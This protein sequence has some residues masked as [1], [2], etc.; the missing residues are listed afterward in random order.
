MRRLVLV[1]GVALLALWG[2]KIETR[3][4]GDNRIFKLGTALDHLSVIELGEPVLE[5]AAG[6]P[7]FKIEWR[8]NKVFVQP[9]DPEASTNLFIWTQ[10]GRLSYELMPAGTV[11][12]MH[13]AIDEEPV[14]ELAPP[15]S[16][17]VPAA[18]VEQPRIPPEMLLSST[19]V[20]MAGNGRRRASVEVL[21]RDVYRRDGKLYLRYAIRNHGRAVY[22]PGAPVMFL[23]RSPR[24]RQSLVTLSNT[25]LVGKLAHIKHEGE[26]ALRMLHDEMQVKAVAPGETTYGLVAFEMPE[27]VMAGEPLV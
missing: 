7:A 14:A 18:S 12:R 8:E 25:Q 22:R 4:A 1:F 2:Q 9:L 11:E 27:R 13:F 16:Q 21:L 15:A 23:L 24:A 20:R 10:S 26:S 6:S 17:P 5:V 19:A 3:K